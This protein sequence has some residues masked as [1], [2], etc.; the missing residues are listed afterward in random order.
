MKSPGFFKLY[1]FRE[2]HTQRHK[3]AYFYLFIFCDENPL[4]SPLVKRAFWKISKKK[5]KS[6]H[7]QEGK[8]RVLKSSHFEEEKKQV[9][10]S[11]RFVENLGKFQ[12]FFFWNVFI[13][14]VLTLTPLPQGGQ[15]FMKGVLT[16]TPLPQGGRPFMKGVLTLTP[17]PPRR[18]TGLT[19]T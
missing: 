8:K 4:K 19:N 17:L 9:L 14:G 2:R 18:M 6:P 11:P 16:L 7:F 10:K 13:K 15:P 1:L 3:A 5:P 12:T